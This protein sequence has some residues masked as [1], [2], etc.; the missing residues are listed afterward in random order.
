MTVYTSSNVSRKILQQ[1]LQLDKANNHWWR[2]QQTFPRKTLVPEGHGLSHQMNRNVETTQK[3]KKMHWP[4]VWHQQNHEVTGYSHLQYRSQCQA[5]CWCHVDGSVV[6]D[7]MVQLRMCWRCLVWCGYALHRRWIFCRWNT[8][9]CTGRRSRL[10]L[11]ISCRRT[12]HH[13]AGHS[14]SSDLAHRSWR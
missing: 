3:K 6:F 12:N 14:K 7:G 8:G 11:K 1:H 4:Y 2:F 5:S 9:W 10:V 13:N